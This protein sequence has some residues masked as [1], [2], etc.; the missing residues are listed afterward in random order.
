MLFQ[1][2]IWLGIGNSILLLLVHKEVVIGDNSQSYVPP[3]SYKISNQ[4]AP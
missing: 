2:T 4:K 3:V 1:I